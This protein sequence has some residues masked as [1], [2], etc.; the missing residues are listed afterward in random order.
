MTTAENTNRSIIRERI[1][2]SQWIP[3]NQGWIDALLEQARSAHN[4]SEEY[5]AG[6]PINVQ[7]ERV[8]GSAGVVVEIAGSLLI[9]S[10]AQR[11]RTKRQA[12]E[13]YINLVQ[14]LPE[15]VEVRLIDED[16][17]PSLLTFISAAPFESEPRERVFDAQIEVM[18]KMDEPLLG[19]H[20]VNV[21]ELPGG[22]LEGQGFASGAVVWSR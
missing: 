14:L 18:Q 7:V 10:R 13:H 8:I 9:P 20:L 11:I 21:Q 2:R 15:V 3:G 5:D 16:E 4:P 1:L 12:Q 6:G 17:G 22:S 19:F